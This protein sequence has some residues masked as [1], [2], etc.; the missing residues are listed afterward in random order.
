MSYIRYA[1]K[2]V[3][4][5]IYNTRQWFSSSS[6]PYP[7]KRGE[8]F[9]VRYYIAVYMACCVGMAGVVHEVIWILMFIMRLIFIIWHFRTSRRST[10]TNSKSRVTSCNLNNTV[11]VGTRGCWADKGL[12]ILMHIY[13]GVV[14]VEF[15]YYLI[16]ECVYARWWQDQA[17]A[18]AMTMRLYK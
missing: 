9:Y 5:T 11:L 17:A 1:D 7:N 4:I 16:Y 8:T 18:A 15:D 14:C 3:K 2:R 13:L 12:Y 10:A 6:S